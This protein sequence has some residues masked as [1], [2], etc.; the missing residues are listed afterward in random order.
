MQSHLKE[1][2]FLHTDDPNPDIWSFETE[3]AGGILAP[4]LSN[5]GDSVTHKQL[6]QPNRSV[7][8]L[9]G[10][11]VI[12]SDAAQRYEQPILKAERTWIMADPNTFFIID[13]INADRPVKVHSQFTLNNA[14]SR[15][16]LKVA[17]ETKLVLRRN[18][19]GMKFFLVRAASNGE[20][21]RASLWLDTGDSRYSEP[22]EVIAA[23]FGYTSESYR[24]EH[25]MV[26]AAARD[27][28]ETV[29]HWHIL[30][31]T[32]RQFYV[33]PS[34]KS[35]GYSLELAQDE[36]LIIRNHSSGR[37]YRI[38]REELTLL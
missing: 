12:R 6:S 35:G 13:R 36:E 2:F 15:L 37:N 27:D 30:P 4:A 34:A 9:D 14:D 20:E 31:L 24:Q 18:G 11:E 29:R 22:V 10:I 25:T 19:A 21:N 8:R 3:E 26:Y 7:M 33:E 16:S 5:H 38:S 23:R 17:A 32:D 1:Q 28:T